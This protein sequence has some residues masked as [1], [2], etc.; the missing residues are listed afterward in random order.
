MAA[1][2]ASKRDVEDPAELLRVAPDDER[3]R[4]MAAAEASYWDAPH[5]LGIESLWEHTPEQVTDR[6]VNERYVNP[7][8]A[9]ARY[10]KTT[11]TVR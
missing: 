1:L 6:Y 5:P 2:G 9:F 4:R 8:N 3:Y 10:R 11:G 7:G